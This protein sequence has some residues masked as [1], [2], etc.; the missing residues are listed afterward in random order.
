MK[1]PK[2][3]AD[4]V[5]WDVVRAARHMMEI[6]GKDA[7]RTAERRAENADDVNVS[8][9]WRAIAAAIRNAAS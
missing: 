5:P 7:V 3:S 1:P 9:R 8:K 6:H 2:Q 4:L